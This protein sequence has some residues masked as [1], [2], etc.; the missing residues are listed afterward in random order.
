MT[1]VILQSGM[2]TLAMAIIAI[3]SVMLLLR[4]IDKLTG[5][6]FSESREVI[7]RDPLATAVYYGFRFLGV[8][9]LVGQ[10]FS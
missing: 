4:W 3:V 2:F 9:M 6:P 1:T 10:L 8:S 5:A 7:K